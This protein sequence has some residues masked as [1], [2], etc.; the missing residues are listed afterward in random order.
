[1]IAS[2]FILF[3][4]ATSS[5]GLLELTE[6]AQAA[7]DRTSLTYAQWHDSSQPARQHFGYLRL[8]PG[9]GPGLQADYQ[10]YHDTPGYFPG[11]YPAAGLARELDPALVGSGFSEGPLGAH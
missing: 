5:L 3:V 10:F 9:T 8:R 1:M 6:A 11:F 4:A 7:P 2:R